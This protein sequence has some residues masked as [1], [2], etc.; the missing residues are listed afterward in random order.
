M[1]R[2]MGVM[3]SSCIKISKDFKDDNGLNVHIVAG[4]EGWTVIYA[5]GS[6]E[7]QDIE[8][9]S[10]ENYNRAYAVASKNLNLVPIERNIKRV[11][12]NVCVQCEEK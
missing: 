11:S 9:T 6:T 2:F 12:L 10:E 1:K 3:P 7:Y 5:D 4:P 8:G